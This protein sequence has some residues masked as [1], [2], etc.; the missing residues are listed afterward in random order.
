MSLV[1][2]FKAGAATMVAATTTVAVAGFLLAS[3]ANSEELKHYD[4]NTK[5]FWTHP[6]DDWF[7]GDETQ[8]LKGTNYLNTMPP[9]TVLPKRKSRPS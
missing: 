9:P 1:A 7:M 3:G 4:S 5:N 6:P 8:E 2:K